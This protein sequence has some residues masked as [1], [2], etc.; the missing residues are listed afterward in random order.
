MTFIDPL[1]LRN[2]EFAKTGAHVGLSPVPRQQVFL[3]SCID[4]RV[5]PAALLQLDLGDVL[6]LRNAGGRV[7]AE[8][9]QEIAFIGSVTEMMAGDGTPDTFEVAV[10]HHT[11]CG[12]GFLA[13]DNFR[14]SFAE[15]TGADPDELLA[16]AV[17]DPVATVKADVELLRSH[18]LL[19]AH[20]LVS[21]HVYDTDTGLIETIIARDQ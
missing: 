20:A 8:V 2:Q 13:D 15:K 16:S 1:L 11:G 17:V 12:T 21:G 14:Q 4:G 19:P 9:V 3:I 18:R 10:M 5:D 6:S 7:N